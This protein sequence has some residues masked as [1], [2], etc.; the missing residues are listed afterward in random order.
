MKL[1][2]LVELGPKLDS[3]EIDSFERR[4]GFALPADYRKF[5]LQSNGGT[6]QE[7]GG[8]FY[9]E[10][11]DWWNQVSV[12]YSLRNPETAVIELDNVLKWRYEQYPERFGPS[13]GKL[14]IA[15]DSCGNEI[16]LL[17]AGS[18]RGCVCFWMHDADDDE[19]D[20]LNSSF[21][22]FFESIRVK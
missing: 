2:E 1:Q 10:P 15:S 8:F 21:G 12:F 17:L 11:M 14:P 7:G 9:I 6:P 20:K 13:F 4:I 19:D 5:L 3:S 16:Y 22:V 18:E